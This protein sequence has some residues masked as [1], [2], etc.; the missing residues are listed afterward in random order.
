MT[1][2]KLLPKKSHP[3]KDVSL[4]SAL[5][6]SDKRGLHSDKT[7]VLKAKGTTMPLK[8]ALVIRASSKSIWRIVVSRKIHTAFAAAHEAIIQRCA[9]ET[10]PAIQIDPGSGREQSPLKRGSGT[11]DNAR[12]VAVLKLRAQQICARET[13]GGEARSIES[14]ARQVAACEIEPVEDPAAEFFVTAPNR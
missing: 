12:Q 8:S 5:V 13:G 3:V 10:G 14:R 2:V 1:P 7:P 11:D 9:D 4:K 6:G